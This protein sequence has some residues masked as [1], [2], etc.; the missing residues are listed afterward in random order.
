M[1]SA[2]P[3]DEVART[4]ESQLIRLIQ[5]VLFAIRP[6]ASDPSEIQ[7]GTAVLYGSVV[8]PYMDDLG[9]RRRRPR[10]A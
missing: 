1:L 6:E 2:I 10:S 4:I 8:T 5:S 7:A 9:C 3:M